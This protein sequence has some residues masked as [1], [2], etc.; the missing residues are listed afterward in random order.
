VQ[1]QD[2]DGGP[3]LGEIFDGTNK[4]AEGA[5]IDIGPYIACPAEDP[6]SCPRPVWVFFFSWSNAPVGLHTLT[7]RA[8]DNDGARGTS[9]PVNITVEGSS[10]SNRELHVVGIYSGLYNGGSSPNHERGDASVIVDRPGKSVTLY[11]SAY[12]PVLWHVSVA[13][14]TI[15]E[16]VFLAGYYQ[17]DITGISPE[18]PLIRTNQ[19]VGYTLDC[20]EFYLSAPAVRRLTGMEISSFHGSYTATETFVIAD[21]QDDP[22]LRSDFPQPVDASGVPSLNFRLAFHQRD[23]GNGNVFFREY[24]LQGPVGAADVIP[25]MRVFA[26]PAGRYYY[27]AQN[28]EV[29]RIDT[30]A[31]AA[32]QMQLPPSLPAFSWAWSGAYDTQRNRFLVV[33]FGG[34]GY[35]YAYSP[36][37]GEWSVVRSMNNLDL[38][39]LVYHAATDQLFGLSVMFSECDRPVLYRLTANGEVLDQMPL[40]IVPFGR[41]GA[42]AEMVSVGDYLVLLLEASNYGDADDSRIYLIDPRT[43]H[44]WLTYRSGAVQDSD[45]DGVPDDRDQ[46]PN[47]PPGVTVDEHGCS[48]DQRDSD[49]DGVPDSRDECPN[50]PAG[51]IVDEHGCSIHQQ[52]PIVL[53]FDE[54][55]PGSN[56][57]WVPVGNGYGGLQWNN[58]GAING[59]LRPANEGYHAGVVSASNVAFNLYGDPASIYSVVPFDFKSAYLTAAINLPDWT[60]Q[61]AVQGFVGTTLVYDRTVVVSNNSPAWIEFNYRGVN[62]VRFVPSQHSTWFALD[63]LA[64]VMRGATDTDGDGVPDSLDQCPNTRAGAAVDEHGCSIAQL[65]PCEGRWT[66]HT[67]YVECVRATSQRFLDAGWITSSQ[68]DGIVE[69]AQH[70]DCGIHPRLI[71]TTRSWEEFRTNGCR[72]I[73]YGEGPTTCVIEC[74]TNLLNWVPI[75]TNTV[76][77]TEI[78]IDDRDA[79]RSPHRFYRLRY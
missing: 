61:L 62:Q 72:L 16:R 23:S 56:D 15:I 63:N 74:S 44:L 73:L 43:G 31:N 39:T 12:E 21:V 32:N 58:F 3:V 47:T 20:A 35:L 30:Q 49:H 50:T 22:R 68:R 65:C 34:E 1:A 79:Y 77:G 5:F 37:T 78:Q 59:L 42:R 4:L 75:G 60:I 55:S 11:L 53:T 13:S 76:S 69:D 8:T 14:N 54:L 51:E 45:H 67:A 25:A 9:A 2:S 7:A 27:G 24:S 48:A 66:N 64:I 18:T 57:A 71:V 70:S 26:D 38:G 46:C 33:S 52:N 19:Y 6:D 36:P 40:A 17:Q 41:Y 29:W 28:H 10:S